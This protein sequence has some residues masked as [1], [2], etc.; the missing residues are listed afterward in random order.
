MPITSIDVARV[1][2]IECPII[3]FINDLTLSLLDDSLFWY[4]MC[5]KDFPSLH[6]PDNIDC[7]SLYRLYAERTIWFH[8]N[9]C[10]CGVSSE[11]CFRLL[12]DKFKLDLPLLRELRFRFLNYDM[13]EK[14]SHNIT[15]TRSMKQ[16]KILELR[17]SYDIDNMSLEE[18]LDS[19]VTRNEVRKMIG[20]YVLSTIHSYCQEKQIDIKSKYFR[21]YSRYWLNDRWDYKCTMSIANGTIK[22]V[23]NTELE[24][25]IAHRHM[26][27]VDIPLHFADRA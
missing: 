18:L 15:L 10:T 25:T 7:K 4:Q 17:E 13:I 14:F 11:H 23:S 8:S 12:H 1:L 19:N 3:L 27:L 21:W 5:Q 16:Q 9:N 26:V 22:H 20:I 2:A 24:F 6:T